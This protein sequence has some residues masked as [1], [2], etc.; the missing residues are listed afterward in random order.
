MKEGTDS[1]VTLGGRRVG[2]REGH[3]GKSQRRRKTELE[4][5]MSQPEE[6]PGNPLYT[7]QGRTVKSGNI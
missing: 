6:F 3:A 5:L 4:V 7:L 2:H 1:N